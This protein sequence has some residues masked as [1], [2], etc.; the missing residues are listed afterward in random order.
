VIDEVDAQLL[1]WIGSA[2]GSPVWLEPP[3]QHGQE[4]GVG[5]YLLDLAEAPP[6]RGERRA[7]LQVQ[8]RYLVTAWGPTPKDEHRLLGDLVF[9]A[10]QRPDWEVAFAPL[11]TAAWAAFGLA[12]RPTLVLQV[13][14]RVERPVKL[15]PRVRMPLVARTVPSV[16]LLGRVLGPE[17]IPVAAARVEL[18]SLDAA[19]ETDWDGRFRFPRVPVEPRAKRIRVR[20]RGDVQE[21][22]VEAPP[23]GGGAVTIRFEPRE[24]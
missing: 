6:P 10:L 21:F 5:L 11:P 15:A 8:L 23:V 3:R 19:A 2:T 9:A 4:K 14:L 12:P 20:A 22:T 13:P 18:P 16:A 24:E 7:P 1:D 17:D